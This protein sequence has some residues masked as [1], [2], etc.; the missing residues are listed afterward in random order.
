MAKEDADLPLESTTKGKSTSN[1]GELGETRKVGELGV[2][3]DGHVTTN[4]LESLKGEAGKVPVGVE[5]Q[6]LANFGDVVGHERLEVR[7]VPDLQRL[8]DDAQRRHFEGRHARH[9]NL[10]N[11]L[12]QVHFDVH[13]IAVLGDL[14][15]LGDIDEIRVEGGQ[16]AVANDPEGIDSREVEATEV[17]DEGV[18]DANRLSRGKT[19]GAESELSELVDTEEVDLVEFPESW[20]AEATQEVHIL[21]L[22]DAFNGLNGAAGDADDLGGV[23]GPEVAA[24]LLGTIDLNGTGNILVNDDV[25][26]DDTAADD[27]RGLSDTDIIGTRALSYRHKSAGFAV[28]DERDKHTRDE[29]SAENGG[30]RENLSRTHRDL[31]AENS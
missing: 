31:I 23:D 19:T 30:S 24:N 6:G 20:H 25:G 22:K 9:L 11:H 27:R 4:G 5:S 15:P 29:R 13:V 3:L 26:V 2:I 12:E 7:V 8:L 10:S 16:L 21:E 18:D 17:A 28:K 1:S 14:E